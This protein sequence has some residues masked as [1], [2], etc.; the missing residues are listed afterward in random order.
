[1]DAHRSLAYEKYRQ[2][3]S[4]ADP[5]KIRL[6]TD[7]A[8]SWRSQFIFYVTVPESD[9]SFEKRVKKEVNSVMRRI[10][11]KKKEIKQ[12]EKD[13]KDKKRKAAIAAIKELGDEVYDIFEEII[14]NDA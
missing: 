13:L 9:D 5:K 6:R 10:H 11:D 2:W 7:N 8:Y 3:T 12:A 14:K 4:T 1:M